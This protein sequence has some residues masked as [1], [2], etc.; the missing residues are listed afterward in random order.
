MIPLFNVLSIHNRCWMLIKCYC[1]RP[2]RSHIWICIWIWHQTNF[3]NPRVHL[4]HIQQCSIQ[5]RNVHFF[6]LKGVLWDMEQVCVHY[7]ICESGQLCDF[8]YLRYDITAATN[9]EIGHQS[10]RVDDQVIFKCAGFQSL[11]KHY[12]DVILSAMASQITSLTIVYSTVYWGADQRKHQISASL[13][14][15]RGIH[16]WSVNSPHKE[17]VTRK[18]FHLMTSSRNDKVPGMYS[19]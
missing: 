10:I 6:V 8:W 19:H 2:I 16:R 12:N 3:T 5:K 14:F 1:K 9:L 13:A 4:F 18:C 17:P 7:E 11:D 15:A